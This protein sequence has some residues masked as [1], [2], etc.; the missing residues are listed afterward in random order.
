MQNITKVERDGDFQERIKLQKEAF[1]LPTLPTTTI[2]SFPQ[3]PDL[4]KL[5][6]DYKKNTITKELYE[7]GIKT[8]ID[9][10]V[11]LQEDIGLDVLVHGEPERNDMVEYFG[12]YLDG[13][14][15]SNNGWVQ[16]Y[17]T[18]CVKPPIIYGDV[19]RPEPMTISWITYAQSLTE[20][21]VKGMLTGPVTILSWSFVRDD[22]PRKETCR[23]IALAIRDEVTDLEAAGIGIIQIDEP[24]FREGA[25]IRSHDRGRYYS[26]AAECFRL[27]TSGVAD[28][29]QIHSHMCYSEFNEIVRQIASLDADVISIEASRSNMELLNAFGRNI[30]GRCNK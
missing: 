21:P 18:R 25:P 1:N 13:F 5:R 28:R 27:A 10:C 26:W 16:S 29:T 3:T 19:S 6:S 24:A 20:K 12:E 8:Y 17:G 14:C 30:P 11:A 7:Q 2:G 9:E 4:R 15:F 22:Q 23:Q